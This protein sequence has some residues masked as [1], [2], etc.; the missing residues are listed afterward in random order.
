MC[1]K[2]NGNRGRCNKCIE[3][4]YFLVKMTSPRPSGEFF[5]YGVDVPLLCRINIDVQGYG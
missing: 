4:H 5:F 3:R 1:G 2:I